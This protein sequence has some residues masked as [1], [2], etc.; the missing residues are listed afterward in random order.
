MTPWLK[1][2][3]KMILTI[4][5]SNAPATDLQKSVHAL[6]PFSRLHLLPALTPLT[7]CFNSTLKNL[8]LFFYPPPLCVP[9]SLLWPT[10]FASLPL[11]PPPSFPLFCASACKVGIGKI[12]KHLR[13]PVAFCLS[14]SA[15]G[16]KRLVSV[17]PC[18]FCC[19]RPN[20][21]QRLKDLK[22]AAVSHS[23][24]RHNKSKSGSR[25]T[26]NELISSNHLTLRPLP[27]PFSPSP[28][29][30]YNHS[31]KVLYHTPWPSIMFGCLSGEG[32]SSHPLSLPPFLQL[33]RSKA[34][35]PPR[36]LVGG[37]L[38]P[39]SW[40]ISSVSIN[41]TGVHRYKHT[42]EDNWSR[43]H[44]STYTMTLPPAGCR[45]CIPCLEARR[46]TLYR[47]AFN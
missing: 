20:S 37:L 12:P 47:K 42:Q 39:F 33:S 3:A 4:Q 38:Q 7:T 45:V 11:H 36:A 15:R 10:S 24:V 34:H 32:Q 13:N 30:I 26:K 23:P 27:H 18:R 43:M 16:K 2:F 29:T 25:E 46:P 44:T 6:Y 14:A 21:E 1:V 17:L 5:R 19:E 40:F 35:A 22:Y 8:T 9:C 41:P 28:Y 31:L